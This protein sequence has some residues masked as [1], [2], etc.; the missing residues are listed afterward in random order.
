MR[1]GRS[2]RA[3]S[4]PSKRR[5]RTPSSSTPRRTSGSRRLSRARPRSR[6]RASPSRSSA[7]RA[8]SRRVR[9]R[10]AFYT[11]RGGVQRRQLKLKGAE[12]GV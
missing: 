3:P 9:N 7:R 11:R 1:L 2:S 4:C 5:A 10:R 6:A 8:R 12:G